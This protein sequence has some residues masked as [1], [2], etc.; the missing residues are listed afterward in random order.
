MTNNDQE[1]LGL[2]HRTKEELAILRD[3][4]KKLQSLSAGLYLISRP[5]LN[6][7]SKR[8]GPSNASYRHYAILDIGS[9]LNVRASVGDG[10]LIIGLALEQGKKTDSGQQI[11]IKS[12]AGDLLLQD[13]GEL[14]I[15]DD[16]EGAR[17]RFNEVGADD[18][19][20]LIFRNCE[21]FA[22]YI[23]FGV[24]HSRQVLNNP[25]GIILS[26]NPS[27]P[28]A[29]PKKRKSKR[30]SARGK[31]PAQEQP[32]QDQPAQGAGI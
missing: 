16:V 2:K 22:R 3:W 26:G 11:K 30:Q 7:K 8:F 1:E 28:V 19:Y 6:E 23:C 17:E 4:D 13:W 31:K 5:L 27:Q 18:R 20:N 29:A 9:T 15:V 10:P 24:A 14:T 32:T 25:I 12:F 21:H